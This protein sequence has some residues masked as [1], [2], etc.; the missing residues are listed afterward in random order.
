MLSY[1]PLK[2]LN[3]KQN[4]SYIPVHCSLCSKPDTD[5]YNQVVIDSSAEIL[6][7]LQGNDFKIMTCNYFLR[8][9]LPSD[10]DRITLPIGFKAER[11]EISRCFLLNPL[12]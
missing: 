2:G 4:T 7:Q 11:I 8:L 5:G 6:R 1:L 12:C 10:S 9:L 3:E